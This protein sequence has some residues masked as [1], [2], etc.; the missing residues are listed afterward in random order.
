[1]WVFACKRTE[2]LGV[3][4]KTIILSVCL[5]AF[6]VVLR[7]KLVFMGVPNYDLYGILK[8]W[9]FVAFAYLLIVY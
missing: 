5:A 6:F 9:V 7:R 4:L 1:M 3:N 2:K 8:W